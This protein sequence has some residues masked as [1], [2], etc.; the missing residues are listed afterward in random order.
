MTNEEMQKLGKNGTFNRV[1]PE[2]LIV[3]QVAYS[4]SPPFKELETLLSSS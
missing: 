2:T 3:A 1:L 4:I